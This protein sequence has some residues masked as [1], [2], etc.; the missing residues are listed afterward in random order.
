MHTAH[1]DYTV[2]GTSYRELVEFIYEDINSKEPTSE[3]AQILYLPSNPAISALADQISEA[4]NKSFL[5]R[6]IFIGLSYLLL[7]TLSLSLVIFGIKNVL[8]P[9][10]K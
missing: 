10:T 4:Q 9:R 1:I 2:Q 5:K 6:N 8:H 7:S 3:N